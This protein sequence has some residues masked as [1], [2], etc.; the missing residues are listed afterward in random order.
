MSVPVGDVPRPD[1]VAIMNMDSLECGTHPVQSFGHYGNY[2]L[3]EILECCKISSCS[4]NLLQPDD[5][6]G[7]EAQHLTAA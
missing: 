1:S 6:T 7:L 5:E 2:S 4:W 3:K